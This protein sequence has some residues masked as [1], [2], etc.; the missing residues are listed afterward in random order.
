MT[1]MFESGDDLGPVTQA[2]MGAESIGHYDA[3]I[4]TASLGSLV[5]MLRAQVLT[6]QGRWAEALELFALHFDSA[7]GEGLQRIAACLLADRAW[8]E[9]CLGRHDKARALAGAAEQAL[10]EPIDIDDR[11]MATA[12]LAQVHEVQGEPGLAARHRDESQRLYARHREQ[13]QRIVAL[14]DQA[15]QGVDPKLV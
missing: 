4:G 10:A 3:G 8:C 5:P 13:Q 15:L 9:L 14:L 11:A 12:R 2:L 6:S 1:M 7:L